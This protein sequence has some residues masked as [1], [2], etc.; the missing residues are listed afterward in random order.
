MLPKS[1]IG[2]ALDYTL[3]CWEGLS[4]YATNGLLPVDNRPVE[5]SICPVALGRKNYLFTGS[6]NA[7]KHGAAYYSL[8]A[9]CK[10]HGIT[11]T[12]G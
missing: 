6:H 1:A 7:A 3:E 12:P 5:N 11:H 10:G 4:P 2:K 8:F 9:T